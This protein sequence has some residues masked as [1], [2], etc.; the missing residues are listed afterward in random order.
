MGAEALRAVVQGRSVDLPASGQTDIG[1][2]D[3]CALHVDDPRVSRFHAVVWPTVDGWVLADRGTVGGTWL[4]D[5]RVDQ[6]VI[7]ATT[8][9]R[10]GDAVDGPTL[11]LVLGDAVPPRAGETAA[12]AEAFALAKSVTR[13]SHGHVSRPSGMFA[14]MY[15]PSARLRIG[16]EPDNDIVVDDLLVSRHHAEL[17]RR[18]D[19]QTELVDLKSLNGTYLN[20]QRVRGVVPIKAAARSASSRAGSRSTRTRAPSRSRPPAS[21]WS[22]ARAGP[23]WTTSASS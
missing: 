1:R 4:G 18:G 23:W 22:G 12:A 13:P 10:L 5:R 16:R 20:G 19:G 14:T 8:Q 9:L 2:A 17:I 11:D 7:S 21:R 3:E 6:L 15:L